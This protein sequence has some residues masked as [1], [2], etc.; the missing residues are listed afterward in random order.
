LADRS[1]EPR[2]EG[3]SVDLSKFNNSVLGSIGT[4]R[5]LVKQY[6]F[7]R[8]LR[9]QLLLLATDLTRI[10]KESLRAISFQAARAM[11]LVTDE[12]ELNSLR[13]A[14]TGSILYKQEGRVIPKPPTCFELKTTAFE[15]V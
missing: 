8:Y 10:Q 6:E 15:R 14:H 7:S 11:F 1:S 12:V 3:T 13:A 2:R 5:L 9:L 4:P